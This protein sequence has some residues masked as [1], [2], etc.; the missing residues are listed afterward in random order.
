MAAHPQDSRR[1]YQPD[2][3]GLG[4]ESSALKTKSVVRDAGK[5][6]PTH[7]PE[8]LKDFFLPA[9]EIDGLTL[10]EALHKLTGAYEEACRKAGEVPLHLTFN[11]SPGSSKR[12][13]LKLA[14]RNLDSSIR[15][16]ATHAGMKV[17]RDKT[18]YRFE[19][20]ATGRKD[21]ERKFTVSPYFKSGLSECAG[22]TSPDDSSPNGDAA[23]SSRQATTAESSLDDI[24]KASGLE[25]DPTTRLSLNHQDEL[26]LET[27]N[28]SDAEMISA[29]VNSLK[30]D[31]PRQH[32]FVTHVIEMGSDL[33]FTPSYN[34][35]MTASELQLL[36]RQMSQKRS[37]DVA[38]MPAVTGKDGQSVDIK[39]TKL[40]VTPA[41][42][43][44]AALEPKYV[45]TVLQVKGG[46]LGF[47]HDVAFNFTNTT[48]ELD[49]SGKK[50]I[51]RKR[52]DVSDSG[53]T[54]DHG[55]RVAV[56]TRPDGSRVMILLTTTMIDATGRPVHP[57][58]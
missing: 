9:V 24:L 30:S 55:T 8:R 7:G 10:G 19:S 58:N 56:Q 45:G 6:R 1:G 57:E 48:G 16:L 28:A 41:N 39:L 17:N 11:I 52:S 26:V 50:T 12:L 14:S 43:E 15:L 34:P 2:P 32:K 18:E 31:V 47:G 29:L 33:A 53:Y 46:A 36:I 44:A 54:D 35:R 37:V 23:L 40:L 4:G 49:S 42:E 27:T 38:T 25:L 13:H 5:P 3:T 22:L 21:V 20:F 51:V